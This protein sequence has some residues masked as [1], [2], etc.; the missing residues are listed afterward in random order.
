MKEERFPVA[1]SRTLALRRS[2]VV[3]IRPPAAASVPG[4]VAESSAMRE[5]LDTLGRV[6]RSNASVLLHG[7]TGTGK[8][9]LARAV[10]ALS[11]R[12]DRPF[13]VVDCGSMSPTLI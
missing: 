2:S 8:E 11:D 1:Q 9:V 3:R 12:R 13:E 10:H 5:L 6:A 4:L 7:E